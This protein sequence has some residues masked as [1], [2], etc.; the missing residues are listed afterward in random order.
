MRMLPA[1]LLTV[2]TGCADVQID[3]DPSVDCS[4]GAGW[5]GIHADYLLVDDQERVVGE[6]DRTYV[7]CFASRERPFRIFLAYDA[8]GDHSAWEQTLGAG[9]GPYD[10]DDSGS[11]PVL[12]PETDPG[13]QA[14]VDRM[15]RDPDRTIWSVI[16]GRSGL[17]EA[18]PLGA[19]PVDGVEALWLDLSIR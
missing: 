15:A 3:P 9:L 14:F 10:V 1:M 4:E 6:L 16:I 19:V 7:T 11:F 5:V 2:S 12:D 17:T 13:F 18:A 8:D